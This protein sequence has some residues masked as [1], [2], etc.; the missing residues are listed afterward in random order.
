MLNVMLQY[1]LQSSMVIACTASLRR[2]NALSPNAGV[3]TERNDAATKLPSRIGYAVTMAAVVSLCLTAG[4]EPAR[5][6]RVGVCAGDSRLLTMRVRNTNI[7]ARHAVHS[8]DSCALART[9][10][11]GSTSG[12]ALPWPVLRA[13]HTML[14]HQRSV[15]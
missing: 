11:P 9:R 15:V 3:C 6:R 14:L 4:G 1:S 8:G 12:A 2:M 10:G 7:P 5:V 13:Y